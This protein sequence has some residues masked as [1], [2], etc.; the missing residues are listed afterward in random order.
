MRQQAQ[1][2]AGSDPGERLL[3]ALERTCSRLGLS[4][5]LLS[6]LALVVQFAAAGLLAAGRFRTAGLVLA[7]AALLD[8]ADGLL[9]ERRGDPFA[10]F[11]DASLDCY[12]E[13]GL[14][15]GLVVYYARVN[16]FLYAGLAC[17]ALAGSVMTGYARARSA[18]LVAHGAGEPVQGLERGFWE[19]PE[20]L[21]LVL[22][23]A[24][25]NR[26]APV[27]WLLAV[28]PN[29]SLVMTILRARGYLRRLLERA[30][31]AGEHG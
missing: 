17:V 24:L 26:M 18:S 7:A 31:M 19:R 9:A 3:E 25:A 28:G 10:Q 21:G 4:P 15:V 12:G 29:L 2:R 8:G 22:V 27:L 20:R 23:G 5:A 30:G 11:F 14:F 1:G 6:L 13:L 16:R